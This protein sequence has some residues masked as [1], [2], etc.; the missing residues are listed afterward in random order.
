M[1]LH[2]YD[3]SNF[4]EKVRLIFGLKGLD[5]RS[6]DVPSTAPK[7]DFTPLTGGH[8]RA[9]ALQ[10]GAEVYA[11]TAIIADELERRFPEPTLSPGDNP[12]RTAALTA[13]LAAWAERD[14]L[15]PLPRY[16]TGLH[17]ARF[18]ESF[19]HDR[20]TLHGKPNPTVEQV[21]ASAERNLAQARP[22]I[23]RVH[24]LAAVAAPY[25][26]GDA[27]GL[28][29]IVVY[30]PLWLLETLGGPSEMIDA[31]PA[32]R[33]WMSRLAALGHGA[34]VGMS[35]SEA[36]DIARASEPEEIAPDPAYRSPESV[37]LGEQISVSPLEEKSAATGTLLAINDQ[38]I[39]LRANHERV[40]EVNVHFPRAG[41]RLRQVED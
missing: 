10:I 1:I 37:G 22:Q 40:G 17:A 32:T 9:P 23:A 2:H 4:S 33:A 13:A 35:A 27:P 19:H 29:D 34:P 28:A 5:W 38:R 8:R 30:H 3:F 20:A 26:L 11:D 15:W 41:Y 39:V 16:I 36:L 24:D 31:A 14:I 21:Q 7:P 25:L 18:P 6:V 12:A